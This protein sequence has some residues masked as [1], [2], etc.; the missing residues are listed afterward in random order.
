MSKIA[1]K[2]LNKVKVRVYKVTHDDRVSLCG[3]PVQTDK[4]GRQY[5]DIPAHQADYIKAV[6]PQYEVGDEFMPEKE[7][8]N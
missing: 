1:D 4:E 7:G 8:K 5:F 6:F 2:I 3:E